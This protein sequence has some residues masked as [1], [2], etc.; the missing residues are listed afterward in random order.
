MAKLECSCR[1]LEPTSALDPDTSARVE[2]YLKSEI[3]AAGS[4]LKAL[5]WVTHSEEQGRRVG[6]RFIQ[7]SA[8]GIREEV[9]DPGV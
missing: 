4:N 3:K 8:G 2:N 1:Y 5:V 7:L 6:T 9:V